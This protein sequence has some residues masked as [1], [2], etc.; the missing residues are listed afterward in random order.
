[1][2]LLRMTLNG[3]LIEVDIN[4]S[5]L[6]LHVLRDKLGLMGVKEGCG[7]GD[8]G[9]CTVILDGEAVTSCITPA[10]KAM[11]KEV[12]TIEGLSNGDELHPIQKAF[13]EYGAIQCG[14]CTPGMILTV[15]A[16]LDKN[17]APT[18]EETKVAISGNL[19]RCGGYEYIIDAVQSLIKR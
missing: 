19:C 18:R 2:T 3:K 7:E 13:V 9:A 8:C 17:P 4:P 15:K 6:L 16:L 11:D 5:D 1:M 10:L 12:I 14:Y